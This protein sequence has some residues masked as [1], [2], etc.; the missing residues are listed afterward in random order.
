[1]AGPLHNKLGH[2]DSTSLVELREGVRSSGHPS[3]WAGEILRHAVQKRLTVFFF[4]EKR[5]ERK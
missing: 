3:S 5:N 4:V 1:V 2:L